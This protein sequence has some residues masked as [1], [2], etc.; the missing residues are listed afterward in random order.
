MIA[1]RTISF[2]IQN[3]SFNKNKEDMRRN[4]AVKESIEKEE[5]D[6]HFDDLQRQL[7]MKDI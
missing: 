4:T 5:M 2:D 3:L 7:E 1:D 6:N